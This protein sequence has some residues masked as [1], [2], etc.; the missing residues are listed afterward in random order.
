VRLAAL[1]AWL[2]IAGVLPA[3]AQTREDLAAVDSAA[4]ARVAWARG[5][6]AFRNHDLTTARA[7]IERAASA[8][9]T[10]PAYL[11]GV[12]RIAARQA[13]TVGVLRALRDYARLG[14][15]RDLGADSAIVPFLALGPFTPIRT[16]HDR[17]RA[18][19]ANS[20]VRAS[21][22]DSSFWPEGVDYDSASGRFYVASVRHRTVAE[23]APG[24]RVRELWPRDRPGLGAML[25][26]RVDPVRHVLWAT[27]SGLP[28]M[29][30]YAAADSA[31]AALLEIDPQNGTI[32]HRWDL[33]ASPQG[34]TLGDLAVGPRG[35]VFLT[36]SNEPVLYRL[37]KGGT[38]L[39]R[40]TSPLFHSLQG[41]APHPDGRTLYLADY[42]HG[43]L[44][45]D[46]ASG[47]VTRVA[48]QP[49]STSL[50]CD[51]IVWYRGAVIAVQNGVSPPR[52]VRFELDSSGARIA[53]VTVLDR[54]LPVADE[55]T[56]GTMVGSSFVYVANS[57]WDKHGDDGTQ[58]PGVRLTAPVLL[59]VPVPR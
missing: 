53:R 18:P 59:A 21:L 3:A 42:S 36:D 43:L 28:Q 26:V 50:G 38:A 14:L 25:G 16:A 8:W 52:V 57:Q 29:A 40:V 55:P 34:H 51:G 20:Q 2:L 49:G 35:D 19:L 6:S 48:D 17:N 11:W 4:A 39:E 23:W 58:R 10:Q 31:I 54:N 27:T 5:V 1:G 22:P 37:R 12:A 47:A 46:L 30:G 9:P 56:I 41:L 44:R 24:G 32:L 13:D 7:E 15:G 33:P 45:V